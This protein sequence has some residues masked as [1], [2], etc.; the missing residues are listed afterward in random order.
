MLLTGRRGG[1]AWDKSCKEH[2]S[3][4]YQQA[5]LDLVPK[6]NRKF[7]HDGEKQVA[8]ALAVLYLLAVLAPAGHE[9]LYSSAPCKS[10]QALGASG[11]A[12]ESV[13]GGSGPCSNPEHHHHPP[14]HQHKQCPLCQHGMFASLA[15][16]SSHFQLVKQPSDVFPAALDSI[17]LSTDFFSSHPARAPPPIS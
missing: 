1:V 10:C 2:T 6:L 7:I 5:V 12:F 13:C 3:D 16:S 11:P 14:G 15:E 4:F 17:R 8:F 9:F